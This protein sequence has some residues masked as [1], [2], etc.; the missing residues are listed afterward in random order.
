MKE[1]AVRIFDRGL[2]R[3]P[4]NLLAC[5]GRFNTLCT[6]R[7]SLGYRNVMNRIVCMFS[8]LN[9]SYERSVR[10][11]LEEDSIDGVALLTFQSRGRHC[12]IARE[13]NMIHPFPWW[14]TRG[15]TWLEA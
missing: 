6:H 14:L 5:L 8:S 15:R 4:L 2:D 1:M 11:R 9:G 12:L 10:V 3:S 13:R 7:R